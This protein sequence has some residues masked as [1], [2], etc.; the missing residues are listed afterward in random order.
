VEPEET[1]IARQGLGKQFSSAT[2]TQATTEELLETKFPIR[3]VQ[4]GYEEEFSSESAVSLMVAGSNI[5]T[6]TLRVV[7]GDEKGSI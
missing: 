4:S 7:G 1:S 5:S 2:D 6:V 3:S